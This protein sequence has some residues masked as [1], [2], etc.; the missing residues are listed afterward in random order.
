M[1]ITTPN[2]SNK[3]NNFNNSNNSTIT[4][5]PEPTRSSLLFSSANSHDRSIVNSSTSSESDPEPLERIQTTNTNTNSNSTSTSNNTFVRRSDYRSK[6]TDQ[7]VNLSTNA[8]NNLGTL[9]LFHNNA[10]RSP[11]PSATSTTNKFSNIDIVNL[12]Q[13]ILPLVNIN[14]SNNNSSSSNNNNNNYNYNNYNN[15]NT[16]SYVDS[17]HNTPHKKLSS[18]PPNQAIPIPA[19]RFDTITSYVDVIYQ[20]QQQQQDMNQQLL[21]S[22]TDNVNPTAVNSSSPDIVILNPS[23]GIDGDRSFMATCPHCSLV[24]MTDFK[25]FPGKKSHRIACFLAPLLLCWLPIYCPGFGGRW[26]DVKHWCPKCRA[27]IAIY[28]K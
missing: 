2:S 4:L 15:N 27:V 8:N 9:K 6:S 3:S 7:I 18:Y 1:A 22:S 26:M 16:T 21:Q 13:P 28:T 5:H 23:D 11:P 19:T 20:Q 17:A 10:A 25:A 12:S 14:T 24:V